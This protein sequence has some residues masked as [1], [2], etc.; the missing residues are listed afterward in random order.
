[1]APKYHPAPLSGGDRK[2]LRKELS[3]ALAMTTILATQSAEARVKGEA[4]IR[5]ADKLLCESWNERMWADG[6]DRFTT[7]AMIEAEHTRSCRRQPRSR[8]GHGPAPHRPG[9]R[10]REAAAEMAAR[11]DE[12]AR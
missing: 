8:I 11:G 3:K 12:G 5:T 7:R 2:A 4:P 6:E 10:T 1:M 9:G